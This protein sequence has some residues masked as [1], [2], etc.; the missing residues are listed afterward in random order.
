MNS[1]LTIF[2]VKSREF[3]SVTSLLIARKPKKNNASLTFNLKFDWKATL[4]VVDFHPRML[5][6]CGWSTLVWSHLS[7]KLAD[8]NYKMLAKWNG[9]LIAAS[10]LLNL[11][12]WGLPHIKTHRHWHLVKSSWKSEF[13]PSAVFSTRTQ[14]S[15]VP[16]K[17]FAIKNH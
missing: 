1:K 15:V 10:C 16:S 14:E 7:L 2:C 3:Y 6:F 17:N 9:K 12:P 8:S 4:P 11:T 5:F 13:H